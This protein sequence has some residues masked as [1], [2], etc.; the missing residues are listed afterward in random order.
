MEIADRKIVEVRQGS[1]E[2]LDLRSRYYTASAAP[3][4]MGASPYQTRSDLLKALTL[5]AAEA[6]DSATQSR[7]DAGHAAEASARS[8]AEEILGDDLYPVT[9]IATVDGLPLLASLDGMTMDETTLFEHKLF[10]Q[11]IVAD[12]DA[13]G[14][15]GPA[16]YWQ[17]ENQLIVTGATR[18]LF[19]T[20]DG[21]AA[22]W[23]H[24]WYES[25]PERREQLVAGWKQFA[26]DLKNYQHVEVLPPPTAAPISDLPALDVQISGS[27]V[28]SNLMQWRDIIERRISDIKT[29]LQDDQDF[30]DADATCKFLGDGEK[31]ID[32][33][34]KQVQGQ[35]V[36]IDEVFRAMDD[37][38]ALMR[39][40]RLELEKLVAARKDAIRAEIMDG[41]RRALAEHMRTLSGLMPEIKADWSGVM[42]GKKTVASLRNAVDTELARA[43]I[44]ANQ[45]NEKIIANIATLDQ[46]SDHATLFPDR[47]AMVLKEPEDLLATI[48]A[49]IADHE[50]EEA[51][52]KAA[53]EAEVQR[54]AEEQAKQQAAQQQAPSVSPA[55]S[56]QTQ[57]ALTI[58][59]NTQPPADNGARIKLGDIS[60]RLGFQLHAEFVASLGIQSV[61]KERAA[62]LYRE[63]DFVPLC[64]ALIQ[65]IQRAASEH[66][67]GKLAKAA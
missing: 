10:N 65:R 54:K 40:K 19:V 18:C 30:A 24:C 51:R 32:L 16:Y 56:E 53:A 36:S 14:E 27:V 20:S 41:G 57:P 59:G 9:C 43:K 7:F 28:A 15:P 48:K 42:K 25:K 4:M 63:S 23:R 35:A 22:Q 31:R 8:L 45:V 6:V 34:K 61:G 12:I 1:P 66:A 46:Y 49:R 52:K 13:D 67:P 33:V 50:A 62:I 37:I 17:M 60:A 3:A 47:R 21:T 5:G 11:Q 58:A 26:E 29:A 39:A 64:N 2:W 38:K 55:A 44:E